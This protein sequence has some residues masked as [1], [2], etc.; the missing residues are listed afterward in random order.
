VTALGLLEE[1]VEKEGG[2]SR[3]FNNKG[4]V[5]SKLGQYEKAV[6]SFDQA[7]GMDGDNPHILFGKGAALVN[8]KKHAQ[9]RE[10]LEKV[11]SLDPGYETARE[12]L[13]LCG[14]YG[15]IAEPAPPG[16]EGAEPCPV[17]SSVMRFWEGNWWCDTCSIYPFLDEGGAGGTLQSTCSQCGGPVRFIEKYGRL[18]CN[19]CMRYEPRGSA[20]MASSAPALAAGSPG[21]C[22][23][24]S[25]PLRYIPQY[26]KNWCDTCRAY[27]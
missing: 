16:E 10:C 27:R 26:G 1:V 8:L 24:C 12:K 18:W 21:A 19:N 14:A 9:A 4:Y 13:T 17:C 5:H 7:L 3:I 6:E 23:S 11:L 20:V 25:S 2:S 15:E 22:Y